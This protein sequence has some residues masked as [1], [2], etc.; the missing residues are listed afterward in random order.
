MKHVL[1]TGVSRGIGAAA[2]LAFSETGAAVSFLYLQ[3]E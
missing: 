2:V 1:I 3:H